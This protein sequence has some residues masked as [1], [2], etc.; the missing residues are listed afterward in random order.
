MVSACV[1]FLCVFLSVCEVGHWQ[2]VEVTV[3]PLS[4]HTC[5]A[6]LLQWISE[7]FEHSNDAYR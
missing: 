2:L 4:S 3:G 7:A 6:G 5:I 1:V